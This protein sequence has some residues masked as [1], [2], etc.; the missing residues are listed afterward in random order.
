MLTQKFCACLIAERYGEHSLL[1]TLIKVCL[2]LSWHTTNTSRGWIA[3]LTVCF[4]S[5][6]SRRISF[7]MR[8]W[9]I[10]GGAN[11]IAETYQGIPHC[12]LREK[13]VCMLKHLKMKRRYFICFQESK[14]SVTFLGLYIYQAYPITQI[15]IHELTELI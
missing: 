5:S 10:M 4:I 3:S 6:A 8:K 11:W 1:S 13:A 2:D 12:L 15:V 7:R 14:F 9:K